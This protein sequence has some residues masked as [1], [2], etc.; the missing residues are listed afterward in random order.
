MEFVELL[1]V[2]DISM[3]RKNKKLRIVEMRFRVV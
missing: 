2:D 1:T 3:D